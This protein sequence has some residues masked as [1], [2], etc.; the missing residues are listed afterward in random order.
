MPENLYSGIKGCIIKL[1]KEDLDSIKPG[2]LTFD[3]HYAEG[4]ITTLITSGFHVET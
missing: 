2:F 4:T 1:I 3:L